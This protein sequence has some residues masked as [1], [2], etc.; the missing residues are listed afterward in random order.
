MAEEDRL[1]TGVVEAKPAPYMPKI[2][3]VDGKAMTPEDLK[4]GDIL[5]VYWVE[6]AKY[7]AETS[8]VCFE[9]FEKF[10]EN[11]WAKKGVIFLRRAEFEPSSA[12]CYPLEAISE[13]R[14]CAPDS[15]ASAQVFNKL[16]S[17]CE[18]NKILQDRLERTKNRLS[19]LMA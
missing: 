7:R 8:V 1:S 19:G 6:S 11:I 9:K 16:S 15:S 18:E 3:G 2:S 14:F 17:L 12:C 4:R 5:V 10:E 13:M